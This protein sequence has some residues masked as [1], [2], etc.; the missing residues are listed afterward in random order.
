MADPDP[1]NVADV[2][3]RF[4]DEYGPLDEGFR[5]SARAELKDLIEN[6]HVDP[7][8]ALVQVRKRIESHSHGAGQDPLQGMSKYLNL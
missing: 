2:M 4:Q 1:Q 6:K 5:E 8:A 7:E 3:K